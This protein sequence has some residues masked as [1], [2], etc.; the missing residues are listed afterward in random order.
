M[1]YAALVGSTLT[2]GTMEDITLSAA[3]DEED[4][5]TGAAGCA[6]GGVT[7]QM[8]PASTVNHETAAAGDDV[9][10]VW[11]WD[12]PYRWR[13]AIDVR[14]ATL[15]SPVRATRGGA[16]DRKPHH[17]SASTASHRGTLLPPRGDDA[18]HALP[19]P[20]GNRL[21]HAGG[22][23]SPP[24]FAGEIMTRA[25]LHAEI[26]RRMTACRGRGQG[27]QG[28][29][30]GGSAP[31]DQMPVTVDMA[32]LRAAID[33][34]DPDWDSPAPWLVHL[35]AAY[36]EVLGSQRSREIGGLYVRAIRDAL[37]PTA[38]TIK[39]AAGKEG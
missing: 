5:V 3:H 7:W 37:A 9:S 6:D 29:L 22:H 14:G 33:E 18:G 17:R 23:R 19:A 28:I 30:P 11:T 2:M 31:P 15:P 39:A 8:L 13:V 26:S 36:T 35:R 32:T 24:L 25:E 10:V 38:T 16:A 21:L 34:L 4:P 27:Q 12:V 1:L 20:D